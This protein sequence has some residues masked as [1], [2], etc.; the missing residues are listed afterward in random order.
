M[1]EVDHTS[2]WLRIAERPPAR[3]LRGG[4]T[5]EDSFTRLTANLV[6]AYVVDFQSGLFSSIVIGLTVGS[7][8]SE[9]S[10]CSSAVTD[11]V[12]SDMM[13]SVL[14]GRMVR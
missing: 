7:G 13:M 5:S 1:G 14:F 9:C 8:G 12:A 6:A 11:C 4:K 10:V 2:Q 3:D